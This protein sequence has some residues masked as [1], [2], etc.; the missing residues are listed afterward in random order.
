MRS[1]LPL[2][3]LL[4][5]ALA[6]C[7]GFMG[8][9]PASTSDSPTPAAV[10][11]DH[12][13]ANPPPGL[14]AGGI[15][16]PQTLAA[17]HRDSLNASSF[18]IQTHVRWQ[19]ANGTEALNVTTRT[20]VAATHQQWRTIT[21]SHQVPTETAVV[22]F[23]EWYNGSHSFQRILVNNTTVRTGGPTFSPNQ[24]VPDR[25]RS[26]ALVYASARDP[27]IRT[28]NGL[29]QIQTTTPPTRTALTE[30]GVENVTN[31]TLTATVTDDGRVTE[32]R[33]TYTGT[34]AELQG[35]RVTG[36]TVVSFVV[37][38]EAGVDRPDWVARNTT[39]TAA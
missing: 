29:I 15:S 26:L 5:V 20:N 24:S 28:T 4:M 21:T 19:Y 11:T 10:P 17:A 36:E 34:V 27:T 9:A 6:G 32:Y 1:A 18:T 22:Q 7:G 2:A 37:P 3:L 13:L 8:S 35:T 12:P 31:W 14:T 38:A 25:Q 23:D 16:D 39:A 30:S 33:V